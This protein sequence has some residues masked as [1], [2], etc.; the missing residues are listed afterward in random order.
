MKP[1]FSPSEAFRI[2]EDGDRK[3]NYSG[4][5]IEAKR[6]A[7]IR[8]IKLP[9]RTPSLMPLDY[10]IWNEIMK[11]LMAG[12]PEGN[13][14]KEKFLKRLHKVAMS[15]DK[16]YINKVILRMKPNLK[17]LKEARGYTPKNDG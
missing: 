5:G 17:A 16:K 2:V 3:G 13:E 1:F 15:L 6:Q 12:A 9:P 10:A 7:K 11:R 8:P 4:K 14:T